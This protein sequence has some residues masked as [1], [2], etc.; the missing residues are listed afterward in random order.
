M[1]LN[2]GS[3]QLWFLR[4]EL[5]LRRGLSKSFDEIS[6][7]LECGPRLLKHRPKNCP[8]ACLGRNFLNICIEVA[9]AFWVGLRL[10]G[11]S[12]GLLQV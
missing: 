9:Q 11:H 10:F 6:S 7:F 2:I 8:Q 12:H 4:C 5:G 1:F 3:K